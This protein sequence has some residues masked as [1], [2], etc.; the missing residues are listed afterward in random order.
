VTIHLAE[1]SSNWYVIRTKARQEDRADSNLRAW[2]V[3]TLAPKIKE[4]RYNEYSGKVSYQVKPLFPGYIFARF[5]IDELLHRVR[6]TRGVNGVVS[7]GG[8]PAPVEDEIIDIIESLKGADGLVRIGEELRPNDKVMVKTGPVRNFVG[9]FE[10]HYKDERRVSILLETVSYQNRL[11]VE[12][13]AVVKINQTACRQ[14][15]AG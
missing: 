4:R 12:R 1:E 15:A 7:F 3:K 5:N 9:I 11:V 2:Q 10:G 14:W 13:E 6:F 8:R